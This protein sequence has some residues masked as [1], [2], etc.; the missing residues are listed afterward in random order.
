MARKAFLVGINDYYP[1]GP[2]GQDL[3]GCVNDVKDIANTLVICG[4]EPK[5]I[6]ICTDNRATKENIMKG[7]TQLV[8]NSKEKDSIVF[9]YSGHGSQVANLTD[10]E[11]LDRKDEVLCPHDMDF[12][13]SYISDNELAKI[14]SK[15]PQGVNLE[16]MLDCCHSGTGTKELKIDFGKSLNNTKNE[17][18]T[19]EE[20]NRPSIQIPRYMEP[21]FDISFHL[22]YNPN[23]ESGWLMSPV[24]RP[25]NRE[26]ALDKLNHT[27]W[28]GCRDEQ[29]SYET[30]IG[31]IRRGI[32]TFHLC[33]ILRKSNG[34]IERKKLYKL[35]NAA[36]QR[37]G[38]SQ[39]PQ[40]ET[41]KTELLDKT[42]L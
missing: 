30:D 18:S 23:V 34:N 37:T 12:N 39:N 31:G 6:L 35:L 15:L 19:F 2:G 17:Y 40:L 13:R 9:Y 33:Q 28:A 1:R 38:Y 24:E 42:F 32:F 22:D 36:I 5:N 10:K 14:F 4:F 3:N 26:I 16:V 20:F 11:E 7:V 29:V 8:A 21:P 27:L 41:S 25:K